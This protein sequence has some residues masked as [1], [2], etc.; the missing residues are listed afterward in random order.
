MAYRFKIDEPP[1]KALRRIGRQQIDIAV[2]HLEA[3]GDRA[4]AIH[5]AR[6]CFKRMRSLLRMVRP[7]LSKEV[8]ANENDAFRD[9]GRLL[10]TARDLQVML[11]TVKLVEARHGAG[12]VAGLDTLRARLDEQHAATHEHYDASL[13]K[14]ALAR[15]GKARERWS[16]IKIAPNAFEIVVDG[17][18]ATYRGAERAMR[19]ARRDVGDEAFHEWRKGVQRHRDHVQILRAA[20]PDYFEAR[21]Q[22]A[23]T[24]ARWLGDD[25]DL[26]LLKTFATRPGEVKLKRAEAR[27]VAAICLERQEE[28]RRAAWALGERLFADRPGALSRRLAVYW[29]SAAAIRLEEDIEAHPAAPA[30]KDT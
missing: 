11:D 14:E 1:Q 26:S 16:R 28:I 22:A 8:Y 19:M 21:F 9:I 10:S 7:G 4:T 5:E 20:W 23:K 18:E 12:T 15:L 29:Q 2:R 24:L 30:P 3:N 25:H 27:A 13:S 6:R 17:F